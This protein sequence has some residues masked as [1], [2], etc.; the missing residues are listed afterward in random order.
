MS[1]VQYA[2]LYNDSIC[3]DNL[4]YWYIEMRKSAHSAFKFKLSTVLQKIC[5]FEILIK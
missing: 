1:M 2:L 4:S 3:S 5:V